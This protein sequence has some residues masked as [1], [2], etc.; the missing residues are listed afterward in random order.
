MSSV[1]GWSFDL[2]SYRSASIL[3]DVE[4]AHDEVKSYIPL[5]SLVKEIVVLTAFLGN[6]SMLGLFRK[7]SLQAPRLLFADDL[8]VNQL[9]ASRISRRTTR[10][11]IGRLM[12]RLPMKMKSRSFLG[13]MTMI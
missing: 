12:K 6:R 3:S 8:A 5:R 1:S 9:S 7:V 13:I 4:M 11:P 10:S 2:I